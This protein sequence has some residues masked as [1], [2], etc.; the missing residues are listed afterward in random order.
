MASPSCHA[1]GLRVRQVR[2]GEDPRGRYQAVTKKDPLARHAPGAR[3]P[4]PSEKRHVRP[5]L[6]RP[7]RLPLRLRR[8][9]GPRPAPRAARL[10][11]GSARAP[12]P[13]A[14]ARRERRGSAGSS[15]RRGRDRRRARHHHHGSAPPQPQRAAGERPDA[16]PGA[17]SLR[18]ARVRLPGA[19]RRAHRPC[20]RRGGGASDVRRARAPR[21]RPRSAG[22]RGSGPRSHQRLP[23]TRARDTAGAPGVREPARRG[24]RPRG[25]R[26]AALQ[27]PARR[28]AGVADPGSRPRRQAGGR[29]VLAHPRGAH[30][31]AAKPQRARGRG[32]P[33]RPRHRSVS[34]QRAAR[35][36]GRRD[37]AGLPGSGRGR[38][39]LPAARGA[40]GR[41][42][43]GPA[44]A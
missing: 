14:A 7:D 41:R 11:G 29:A 4:Q 33:R 40:P 5:P 35:G 42:G 32:W 37:R 30:R 28:G 15:G 22:V 27:Q 3:Q 39:H 2:R 44:V 10:R 6:N 8:R 12:R 34:A 25:L 9:D 26:A 20:P 36:W 18:G 31:A 43:P 1:A 19:G 23:G 21:D 24:R 16:G 38:R 13:P 17:A